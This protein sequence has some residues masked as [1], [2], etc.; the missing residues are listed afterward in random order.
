[1]NV[2]LATDAIVAPLTGIGRYAF[3]LAQRLPMHPLIDQT[4]FSGLGAGWIAKICRA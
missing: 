2:I 1:M 4:R 3:E